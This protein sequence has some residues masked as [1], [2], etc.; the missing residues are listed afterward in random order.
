[1]IGQTSKG[2]WVLTGMR[3]SDRF[4]YPAQIFLVFASRAGRSC[5]AS[6]WYDRGMGTLDSNQIWRYDNS[7]Q[8]TPLATFM[9]LGMTSVSNAI[10]ALAVSLQVPDTGWLDCARSTNTEIIG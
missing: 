9:N 7:D 2:W 6:G 5:A 3:F 8:V 10:D 4:Q 1:L